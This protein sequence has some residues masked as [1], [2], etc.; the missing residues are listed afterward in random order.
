MKKI[1]LSLIFIFGFLTHSCYAGSVTSQAYSTVL[2]TLL[3]GGTAGQ[4][5]NGTSYST[6]AGGGGGA[7]LPNYYLADYGAVCDGTHATADTS[8]LTTVMALM[9]TNSLTRGGVLHFPHGECNFTST[10][11]W[12][13]YVAGSIHD[14]YLEGD[15]PLSTI[16][17]FGSTTGDLVSFD[18]GSQY[19][20]RNLEIYGT[21]SGACLRVNGA[22]H[23]VEYNL[24][25]QGCATG[26]Y[27]SNTYG[28]SSDR[29]WAR[30]NATIAC[31]WDGYNTT[32]DF[33]NTFCTGTSAQGVDMN[34]VTG[35]HFSTLT[36]DG[37]SGHG[38]VFS[39]ITSTVFDAPYC[40]S[41]TKSCMKF[42]TS[43]AVSAGLS[44]GVQDIHG[45][46][47][48][49]L[50]SYF[51]STSS[52][53]T[54]GSFLELSSN[55]SRPIEISI[56]GAHGTPNAAGD[57]A[58]VIASTGGTIRLNKQLMNVSQFSTADSISAS[59]GANIAVSE[60]DGPPI[61]WT[62]THTGFSANPTVTA[63]Y[64][65]N[66][67]QCTI[68]YNCTANGTSNSANYTVTNL[69]CLASGKSFGYIVGTNAGVQVAATAETT[70]GSATL[71]L[72]N[73]AK[74]GGG[75][76]TASGNKCALF[77]MTYEAQ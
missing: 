1:F 34:G 58:F 24:R 59:G 37:V 9:Q 7:T 21:T 16:L 50:V 14:V 39:N 71:T 44:S 73:G 32:Q 15:G 20:V 69:P 26:R 40:E 72:T 60:P 70:S 5:W 66:G 48:N 31:K 18:S 49:G 54:Y 55:D 22:N 10:M 57:R 77:S 42:L 12:A 23:G 11:T 64:R 19:G 52:A 25:L 38:G 13:A 30:D 41:L 62:P 2:D 51:S 8:A 68:Y 27:A 47:I 56:T 29:L 36:M 45:V 35:S 65:R 61:S 3:A 75:L 4:F 43:N 6:P 53:G 63:T 74:T 28:I 76:W 17:N 67:R 46:A 33:R